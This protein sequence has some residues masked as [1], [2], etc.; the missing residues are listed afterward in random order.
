MSALD[1]MEEEISWSLTARM[2]MELIAFQSRSV[3]DMVVLLINESYYSGLAVMHMASL[4]LDYLRM[5]IH[6]EGPGN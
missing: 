5:N 2:R 1:A 6:K 3:Y 4:L